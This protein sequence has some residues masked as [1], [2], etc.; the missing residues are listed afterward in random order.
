MKLGNP[1]TIETLLQMPKDGKKCELVDGEIVV[2]PAGMRHSAV[3]LTIGSALVAFVRPRKLG[4]VYTADVG[5]ILPNGNV[6]SPD[7][8]FVSLEKLPGG[9]S[10][11]S[12]GAVVP[13]LAVEVL[14]PNDS[15]RRVGDKIG[16][17]FECGVP[18]VWLV[19]PARQT[20]TVY[21]S[22]LETELL[23][24]DDVITAEPVL[25]GFSCPVA[26]FF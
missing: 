21:R 16:E 3:A 10:P 6:R 19:D 24:V 15:L 5:I 11:E 12:Y 17:Y 13:D 18:L 8:T 23:T 20:V 25:P 26:D 22:L 7:V 9:T 1:A 4:G 2:S 14:S